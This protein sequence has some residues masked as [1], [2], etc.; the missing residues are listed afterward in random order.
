MQPRKMDSYRVPPYSTAI[1][2]GAP[3]G[4]KLA[5][6]GKQAQGFHA[7]EAVA[8]RARSAVLTH[9]FNCFVEKKGIHGSLYMDVEDVNTVD[10]KISHYIAVLFRTSQ[11]KRVVL[12]ATA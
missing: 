2:C 11:K 8:R 1:A 7:E 5:Q 6:R 10:Y 9:R 4:E 3:C 12:N